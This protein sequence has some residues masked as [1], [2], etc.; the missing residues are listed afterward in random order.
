MRSGADESG[1]LLTGVAAA[2]TLELRDLG[3]EGMDIVPA[4]AVVLEREVAEEHV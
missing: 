2:L 4:I 1:G 3:D